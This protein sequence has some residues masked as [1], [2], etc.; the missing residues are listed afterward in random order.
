MPF[1]ALITRGPV[2]DHPGHL[3]ARRPGHAGGGGLVRRRKSP[4]RYSWSRWCMAPPKRRRTGDKGQAASLEIRVQR[5]TRRFAAGGV[6]L[7]TGA[8][9]ALARPPHLPHE[10]APHCVFPIWGICLTQVIA[11]ASAWWGGPP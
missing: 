11:L 1:P 5:F 4:I 7:V 8:T 2:F 6:P 3:L 9:V 10:P